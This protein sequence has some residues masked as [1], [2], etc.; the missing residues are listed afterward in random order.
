MY[1]NYQV[2]YFVT[3]FRE[4]T[5]YEIH[6]SLNVPEK[7]KQHFV[8]II[9]I[10][11]ELT[12]AVMCCIGDAFVGYYFCVCICIKSCVS[13]FVSRSEI[14]ISQGD[15]QSILSIHEEISQVMSLANEFLSYP[16]FINVLCNMGAL[17][18]FSYAVVFYASDDHNI[19]FM[20]IHGIIQCLMSLLLLMIPA[21][22]C[23]RALNLAQEAINSLP[24]W[25]PQHRKVLKR[26]ILQKHSKKFPLMLWNIYVI[27]ESLLI[28]A[29]GTLLT[30]GFLLGSIEIAKE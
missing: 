11:W 17:F 15:Y 30:Y 22:G 5:H 21:A 20:M 25:L 2:V 6:N 4:D 1:V 23:N 14:L 18:G 27:D 13:K 29:F 9:D 10:F 24:G 3:K 19:Y 7:L 12:A 26:H 8:F 28:S 16:A